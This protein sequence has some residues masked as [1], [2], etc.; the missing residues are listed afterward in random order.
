MY[1][2]F[3]FVFFGGFLFEDDDYNTGLYGIV[4]GAIV[5][6]LFWPW[7]FAAKIGGETQRRFFNKRQ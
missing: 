5:M 3:A 6:A 7:F 2:S 1:F 4:M